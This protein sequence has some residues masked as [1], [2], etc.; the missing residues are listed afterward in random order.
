[1]EVDVN[2]LFE[3]AGDAKVSFHEV[4]LHL[5]LLVASFFSPSL[6]WYSWLTQELERIA[7]SGKGCDAFSNPSE[8][9]K[10]DEE[11]NKEVGLSQ[12]K[13]KEL[14]QQLEEDK[15]RSKQRINELQAA[16]EDLNN[17]K[18]LHEMQEEILKNEIRALDRL[19]KREQ[20]TNYEYLRNVVL[21]YLA[22]N[23]PSVRL[24]PTFSLHL[25]S[26]IFLV[27]LLI[28]YFNSNKTLLQTCW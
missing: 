19:T 5:C 27:F 25:P 16:L 13:L 20:H 2:S 8:S 10:E 21:E 14:T 7:F 6:Q 3:R 28:P 18:H 26:V 22:S 15:L 1:L 12:K 9:N 4:C 23:Q 24:I 17:E 11:S